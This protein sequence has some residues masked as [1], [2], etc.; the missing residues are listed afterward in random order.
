LR[1]PLRAA[2]L[3]AP[4]FLAPFL[5]AMVSSPFDPVPRHCTRSARVPN[6]CALRRDRVRHL[7]SPMTDHCVAPTAYSQR[8]RNARVPTSP[9]VPSTVCS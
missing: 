2:F 3:R 6:A 4:F 5:A 9:E 7:P 8:Q 1:A